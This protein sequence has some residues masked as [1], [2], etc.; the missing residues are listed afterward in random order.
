MW[1]FNS[2]ILLSLKYG[3]N[4]IILD[5]I[6]NKMAF[7]NLQKKQLALMTD[8]PKEFLE[9]CKNGEVN[10]S[11]YRQ[12]FF[13]DGS[14][15][16]HVL[17]DCLMNKANTNKDFSDHLE[18]FSYILE[19]DTPL[20]IF[21]DVGR[22]MS[23][24]KFLAD[25]A[26]TSSKLNNAITTLLLK[27]KP[28][29][30]IN[31]YL[32]REFICTLASQ[33]FFKE[34]D[35]I[36]NTFPKVL[37]T[38][39]IN[40]LLNIAIDIP[41]PVLLDYLLTDSK[42]TPRLEE[43]ISKCY[44][45][46]TKPFEQKECGNIYKKCITVENYS[47]LFKIM[48]K[49]GDFIIASGKI[50]DDLKRYQY[51]NWFR[52]EV[53]TLDMLLEKGNQDNFQNFYNL[54]HVTDR[55]EWV[56]TEKGKPSNLVKPGFE[57]I[58]L[59]DLNNL[60]SEEVPTVYKMGVYNNLL[61]FSRELMEST[62]YQTIEKLLEPLWDKIPQIDKAT[63]YRGIKPL[64]DHFYANGEMSDEEIQSFA[65]I[66]KKIKDRG[67]F[68]YTNKLFSRSFFNEPKLVKKLLEAGLGI[69]VLPT[70]RFLDSDVKQMKINIFEAYLPAHDEYVRNI[71][72]KANPLRPEKARET[73]AI[74]YEHNPKLIF[75]ETTKKESLLKLAIKE[76]CGAIFEIL[77]VEDFQKFYQMD[78][79]SLLDSI[80]SSAKEI[81]GN[82][83]LNALVDKALKAGMFEPYKNVSDTDKTPAFFYYFLSRQVDTELLDEVYKTVGIDLNHEIQKTSFWKIATSKYARD[84]LKERVTEK[85]H[86]ENLDAIVSFVTSPNEHHEHLLAILEV[87]PDFYKSKMNGDNL[88]HIT[89]K[90]DAYMKST[91]LAILY[92][93]LAKE[94][95]NKNRLPVSYMID[96]MNEH[97]HGRNRNIHMNL[98]EA[99]TTTIEHS[100]TQ[101][102][103]INR[104]FEE[105]LNSYPTLK[106]SIKDILIP[107]EYAKLKG[108]L[109]VN[110]AP[111]GKKLKI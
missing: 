93:E 67:E 38:D 102:E 23:A 12:E 94:P 54:M 85:I 48:E 75:N 6:I 25:F 103:K 44:F 83:S 96:S 59:N 33:G 15:I 100:V 11:S 71:Y 22:R 10:L 51:T 107:Y 30:K 18:L 72:P 45:T 62:K 105:H 24:F 86:P 13:K 57:D 60:F 111:S 63:S 50:S 29:N 19:Q 41:T 109:S 17:A 61:S 95:N 82:N 79:T 1:L 98:K 35:E 58:V 36:I 78:G 3:Y 56:S 47:A 69:D 46:L 2:T 7:T 108:A 65:N 40:D 49:Y 68:Q 87:I 8:K 99:F 66:F 91:K 26:K 97:L 84:Y 42:I 43:D 14:G 55:A 88:L 90:N 34:V 74:L 106:E 16:F 80:K 77:T 27:Q 76:N 52:K 21:Q 20:T 4:T 64:F 101:D 37:D 104:I 70:D 53:H 32:I 81:E 89:A 92:P 31:D 39:L 28:E 5:K 73:L 9:M 110:N